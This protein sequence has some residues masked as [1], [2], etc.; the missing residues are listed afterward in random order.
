M[1][2]VTHYENTVKKFFEGNVYIYECRYNY[3][4]VVVKTFLRDILGMCEAI[5][6]HGR[7]LSLVRL[8]LYSIR[9]KKVTS[10]TNMFTS[11]FA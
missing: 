4:Q 6:S 7:V 2:C 1:N 10:H 11:F 9:Q 3:R 5:N 8:H